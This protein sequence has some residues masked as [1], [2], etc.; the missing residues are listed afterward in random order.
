MASVPLFALFGK[1]S[2]KRL[3]DFFCS[4]KLRFYRFFF[5]GFDEFFINLKAQNQKKFTKKALLN[6]QKFT[7]ST[8][9]YRILTR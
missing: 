7:Q 2:S 1:L 8:Q 9:I 4:T 6:S 3:S 5:Y